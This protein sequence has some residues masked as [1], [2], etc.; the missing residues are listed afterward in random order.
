MTLF[1]PPIKIY[2]HLLLILHPRSRVWQFLD[3]LNWKNGLPFQVF[4]CASLEI[5][6]SSVI[7][8]LDITVADPEFPRGRAPTRNGVGDTSLLFGQILPKIACK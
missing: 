6:R 2:C 7:L 4:V 1:E 5:V 3:C 8:R